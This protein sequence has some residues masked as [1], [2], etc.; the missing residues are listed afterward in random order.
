[1]RVT[2]LHSHVHAPAL[3]PQL[4]FPLLLSILVLLS[5]RVL[6]FLLLRI[7]C[8]RCRKHVLTRSL[9]NIILAAK[10]REK[11]QKLAAQKK[12]AEAQAA[13]R[14]ASRAVSPPTPKSP[15]VVKSTKK[16]GTASGTATPARKGSGAAALEQR[17]M[18]LTAL[19]LGVDDEAPTYEQLKVALTRE[20]VL[21]EASKALE[22]ESKNQAGISLIVIGESAPSCYA[23]H[24]V[25]PQGTSMP[26]SRR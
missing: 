26:G 1:M 15:K 2:A 9:C 21:A 5:L 11:A 20:T 12:A 23:A 8:C 6:G 19:G 4:H 18:D 13:S 24:F 3:P 17:N 14:A 10:E 25:M 22:A 7:S 16:T